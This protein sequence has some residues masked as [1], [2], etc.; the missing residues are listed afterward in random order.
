[1]LIYEEFISYT[2][3]I[4]KE[5]L[6]L[7]FAFALKVDYLSNY[8]VRQW[9]EINPSVQPVSFN[10]RENGQ[11]EVVVYQT[12]KDMQGKVYGN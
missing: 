6:L 11:I 4:T 1:M 12:V 5:K 7:L 2:T 10:E 8:W 9:K 3:N